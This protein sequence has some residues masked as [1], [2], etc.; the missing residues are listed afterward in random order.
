VRNPLEV[1]S[2][3]QE[4]MVRVVEV[5]IARKRVQLSMKEV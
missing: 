2:L 1:V 5:D 3:N 4:V